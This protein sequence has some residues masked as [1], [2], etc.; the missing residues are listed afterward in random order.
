MVTDITIGEVL[1]K[2]ISYEETS[3]HFYLELARKFSE[4]EGA[5]EIFLEMSRDESMH[6]SE[7][8]GISA[9]LSETE[10]QAKADESLIGMMESID[11]I[12]MRTNLD[13]IQTIREAYEIA[14]EMEF[15]EINNLFLYLRLELI[16]E[17][18]RKEII[19][20]DITKHTKKIFELMPHF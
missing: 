6:K 16:P 17:E 5:K 14:H 20:S 18:T 19:K 1:Q 11:K 12:Q 8:E 3:K 10:L 2:A 13:K 9:Q 15:T 7:L 4:N